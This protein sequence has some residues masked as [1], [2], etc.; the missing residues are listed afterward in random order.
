MKALSV[1]QPFAELIATGAKSVEVRSWQTSYRGSLLICAGAQWHALGVRLH[2]CLGTRGVAVCVVELLD[3]RPL[4]T[5]DATL[6]CVDVSAFEGHRA[7]VLARPR[8]VEPMP[9]LGKLHLFTPP[10]LPRL[11]EA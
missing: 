3:C 7:W 5:R 1:R 10:V 11:L 4:V 2:G 9:M 8:R 6:A